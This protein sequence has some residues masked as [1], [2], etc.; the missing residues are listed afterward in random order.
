MYTD[1]AIINLFDWGIEGKHYVKLKNGLIDYPKGVTAA[2]TG[3]PMFGGFVWGNQFL[4]Y[5]FKGDP[6]DLW[7]KMAAFNNSALKSVGLGFMFNPT[8]VKTEYAACLN[9]YQQYDKALAIGAVDPDKLLPEFVSKLKD[10]G[11]DK[12]V[13]EKQRQFDEWLNMNVKSTVR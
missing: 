7:K 12:I 8:P 13:A 4:S 2:N 6:V 11:C 5:I 9:V 1:R 3:Y 10:A